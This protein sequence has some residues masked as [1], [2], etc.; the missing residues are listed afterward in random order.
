MSCSAG[1]VGA[2]R[3]RGD[4]GGIPVNLCTDPRE[5]ENVGIRQIPMAMPILAETARY[6]EVLEKYPPRVKVGF[7]GNEEHVR[8][9]G[10]RDNKISQASERSG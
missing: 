7:A 8:V 6:K 4:G 1:A 3:S 5:E 10:V 2:S 9:M